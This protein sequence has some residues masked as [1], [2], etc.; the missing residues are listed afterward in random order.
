[1]KVFSDRF[2]QF[3]VGPLRFDYAAVGEYHCLD[4]PPLPGGWKETTNHTSWGRLGNWQVVEDDGRK[5]MQQARL[6]REGLPML[7]AGDPRWRDCELSAELRLLSPKSEAG[8]MVRYANNRTHYSLRLDGAGRLRLVRRRHDDKTVLA[9]TKWQPDFDRYHELRVAVTGPRI[10]ASL[11][12]KLVFAVEDDHLPAG[13]IGLLAT[14]PARF[15]SAEVHMAEDEAARLQ[16]KADAAEKELAAARSH[17][18]APVLWRMIET[19]N[20]GTGRHLRFGDLDGDGRLELVLAQYTEVLNGGDFPFLSCL[21]AVNLDGKVLWQWGEPNRAHGIIPADLA[22]QIHDLDGD[23]AAEVI[24][25]RNFEIVVLDG[26]TGETK[27]RAPTPE[28]GKMATWLPEDDLFRIPG[29]SLCFAD[30]R[31]A[32]ARRDVLVKDRYSNVW[33]YDDRLSPLWH[34]HGNT[35]HFPAVA[36]LDGDGRDEVMIGYTLVDHNGTVLWR[37]DVADHQDA[38]AIAPLDAEAVGRGLREA[39]ENLRIALACGEGGTVVCDTQG[40]IIWRDHTG[41]VQRL[42]AARVR[43]DIPGL[44]IVTKTFWGNPDII[45]LYDSGGRML[46]S[47]ELAG[48]GAVLSPVN[49]RGDGLDLLLTSGSLRLGGLLDGRLRPVV[50]FPDDGHPTLCAEA[51]DL[52]GDPRDEIVLWDLDRIWIYTQGDLAPDGP[53]RRPHRQPHYNMSD[54]RAEISLYQEE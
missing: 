35:G 22:F 23:G 6:R 19:P 17:Y 16:C 40:K 18:P 25:C 29:D 37:L 48:G 46:E 34:F 49:W 7:A 14:G 3:P 26:R 9:E 53:V 1:M 2:S 44:Q 47:I 13:G 38:I 5:V 4:F 39:R 42:T 36:D 21:T 15:A 33:A 50:I 27:H 51:L 10:E 28:P 43:D 32:G 52:T 54:Y 20:F 41:H 8:V 31:G 12:G 24:C 11:D 45:C 30:L